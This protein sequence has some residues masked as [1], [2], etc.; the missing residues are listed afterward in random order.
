MNEDERSF[1]HCLQDE[2]VLGEFPRANE[3]NED[4]RKHVVD[5]GEMRHNACMA[6]IRTRPMT[7]DEVDHLVLPRTP[8]NTLAMVLFLRYFEPR[9]R[10]TMHVQYVPYS[11]AKAR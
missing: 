6:T 7:R 9:E 2:R 10:V 4:E 8:L 5:R 11:K 3:T 1:L